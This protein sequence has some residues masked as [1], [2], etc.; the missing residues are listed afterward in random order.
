M[1]QNKTPL[2]VPV[3]WFIVTAIWITALGVDLHYG[4]SPDGLVILRAL[5]VLTSLTAAIVNLIRYK[6]TKDQDPSL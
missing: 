2:F 4:E 1:K 3:L 5:C 6:Q